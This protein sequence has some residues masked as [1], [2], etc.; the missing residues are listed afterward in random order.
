MFFAKKFPSAKVFGLEGSESLIPGMWSVLES[1]SRL[2]VEGVEVG[3]AHRGR[4]NVLH[5]I[6]GISLSSI[7]NKFSES[8]ISE[9]GDV[10]Y[11]LGTLHTVPYPDSPS[12][13]S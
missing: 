13:H 6:F 5:N 1:S 3:M 4:M 7:C 2:G 12:H 8:E 11:H 9:L 10:K